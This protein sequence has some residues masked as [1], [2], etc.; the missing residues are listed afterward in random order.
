M[1][2]ERALKYNDVLIEVQRTSYAIMRGYHALIPKIFRLTGR[3][4]LK[5]RTY[6]PYKY[7]RI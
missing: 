2:Q 6:T 5:C 1:K 4:P 3:L 7:S